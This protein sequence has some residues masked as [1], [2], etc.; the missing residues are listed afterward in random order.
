MRRRSYWEREKGTSCWNFCWSN[1]ILNL[2]IFLRSKLKLEF[3]L[4]VKINMHENKIYD[5]SYNFPLRKFNLLLKRSLGC[6]II[7]ELVS[8]LFL[9]LYYEM[10]L[11]T[12]IHLMTPLIKLMF[13]GFIYLFERLSTKIE[14]FYSYLTEFLKKNYSIW[15][16]HTQNQ[17]YRFHISERYLP[18]VQHPINLNGLE[19]RQM[20]FFPKQHKSYIINIKFFVRD[21]CLIVI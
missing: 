4:E 1:F 19:V 15:I 20:N 10:E 17:C 6:F 8:H 21:S 7:D 2:K 5:R 12:L 14:E 18:S 9:K 3:K 13:S 16:Q 11:V